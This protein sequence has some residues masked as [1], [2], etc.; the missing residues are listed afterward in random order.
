[1]I[2]EYRL[3]VGFTG[4][5]GDTTP[6]GMAHDVAVVR[7]R[8]SSELS[9][10][11]DR[12][13][14][15]EGGSLSG[16]PL[17]LGTEIGTATWDA[18][19]DTFTVTFPTSNLDYLPPLTNLEVT[20]MYV[21]EG[22]GSNSIVTM[23][24]LDNVATTTWTPSTN[25]GSGGGDPTA[26]AAYWS[27]DV[28]SE[29]EHQAAE[30]CD[31]FLQDT[32]GTGEACGL[33]SQDGDAS[34][35]VS[36]TPAGSADLNAPIQWPPASSSAAP[37]HG[38]LW[39]I[40]D[41]FGAAPVRAAPVLGQGSAQTLYF[42]QGTVPVGNLDTL[43]ANGNG[44]DR[45]APTASEPAAFGA[46]N[47]LTNTASPHTLSE[48]C[49]IY[50]GDI[51]LS[52]APMTVA[53][54]ASFAG[55][56]TS[57]GTVPWQV[58]VYVATGAANPNPAT[59]TAS[60]QAAYDLS[61]TPT[62]LTMTIPSVTGTGDHLY[63][64]VTPVNAV[65]G[66]ATGG[67]ILY[68]S[69]D[70]PSGVQVGTSTGSSSTS[71]SS[72]SSSST[73]TTGSPAVERVELYEASALLGHQDVTTSGASPTAS[74]S[75]S[76]LDLG[77]GDHTLTAKWFDAAVPSSGTPL[78]TADV[79]FTV[80]N[81]AD[82]CDADTTDPTISAAT[83][84]ATGT[85][86]ATVSW[87]T[88]EASDGVVH[89]GTTAG[90]GSDATASGT[91]SHSASLSGL[92]A[93]TTYH[94][95]VE[96]T[97]AC[98]NTAPSGDQTFTTDADETPPTTEAFVTID[99]P[100]D[101]AS[102]EDAAFTVDGTAGHKEA[103]VVGDS[104]GDGFVVIAVPDTGINPYHR[105]FWEDTYPRNTDSDP[106][107]DVDFRAYPGT[108]LDGFPAA[109]PSLD[110]T[111]D[112]GFHLGAD[113]AKFSTV[114]TGSLRWI[115]GTKIIGAYDAGDATTANGAADT[116]P[117][118]D[119]EGT[120]L[121]AGGHGTA[122]SSVAAGNLF[123]SCKECLLVAVESFG[124]D[125]WAYSQDWIDIVT[126]SGGPVANI[127]DGSVGIF[128]DTGR[129]FAPE[130]QQ[131]AVE[132]GVS[133]LYAG[134]NG[135]DGNFL[136]PGQTYL[137]TGVGPGW[138]VRVGAVNNEP[139][140]F[141]DGSYSIVQSNKPVDISSYGAGTI[142][143]AC[144]TDS[145]GDC[146]HS[147]TSS[148]TPITAGH[149]G[150]LILHA[151]RMLGDNG[152]T[153]AFR[154]TAIN[155]GVV[156]SGTPVAGNPYLEDGKFTRAE[157]WYI[158]KQAASPL[159]PSPVDFNHIVTVGVGATPVDYAYAGYGVVDDDA[160]ARAIAML[161]DGTAL[162]RDTADAD[163]FFALD[164][165]VRGALWGGWD[166]DAD[167]L[168]APALS[169]PISLEALGLE[170][171]D[172]AGD[173]D[174]LADALASLQAPARAPAMAASGALGPPC[175]GTGAASVSVYLD[176]VAPANLLGTDDLSGADGAC[177]DDW[178][179]DVDLT[180]AT[181]GTHALVAVYDDGADGEAT[182][183]V[184]ISLD[185]I[186]VLQDG[187]PVTVTLAA[188]T[189]R[190]YRVD[191]PAGTDL[192]SVAIDGPECDPDPTVGCT[193]DADLFV[194]AG[195]KPT[196]AEVCSAPAAPLND[197]DCGTTVCAPAEGDSDEACDMPEPV[198]GIWYVML[199]PYAGS[200]TLTLVADLDPADM[201]GDGVPDARDDD[202]NGDGVPDEVGSGL[203]DPSTVGDG[204]VAFIQLPTDPSNTAPVIV[205]GADLTIRVKV[206]TGPS[207]ALANSGAYR[208]VLQV[209]CGAL[210]PTVTAQAPGACAGGADTTTRTKAY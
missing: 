38:I 162:L 67:V 9:A 82:P 174:L 77:A 86:T 193:F 57:P 72:S 126:V 145:T 81:G 19:S 157:A 52:G 196:G 121:F 128:P 68:D 31:S 17:S 32:T 48:P 136:T 83:A 106:A 118:F 14:Q 80:S 190:Y 110:L 91:T 4:P 207:Y 135:N 159:A 7:A 33:Y 187:Q 116:L 167:T 25:G 163:T 148:A 87:S 58:K 171:L 34:D 183:Q 15:V 111:I 206:Y 161:D 70:Y 62:L 6:D 105:D 175:L 45:T 204:M 24:E 195:A 30:D 144:N 23:D 89:Y 55:A 155:A 182:A 63:V 158:L 108:Y 112:G 168:P 79:T 143:A 127:P 140:P 102:L 134:G 114:P 27:T 124:G 88:D 125:E 197:A 132:R 141:Q 76:G 152:R 99:S 90:Y 150:D 154:D 60:K 37:R 166:D 44:M 170:P 97:D 39:H 1:H 51:D 131:E 49:W 198:A 46:Q 85:T 177:S 184:G 129:F 47:E 189:D 22:T 209:D 92:T 201:D 21:I 69:T 65:T 188:A 142:P 8:G 185:T 41:L 11:Y 173:S 178:S 94:Y 10:T 100:L 103:A 147:G 2:L 137:S 186:G 203:P 192:L 120:G 71:S 56:G 176:S 123:G 93:A 16:G 117:L 164:Q 205:G 169:T 75:V 12:K 191:V 172:V 73:S 156:A 54:Y 200:G 146:G 181:A 53:W 5:T 43:Y 42:H 61:A 202:A 35:P 36:C 101:G 3:N 29:E 96:S 26:C 138:N 130:G 179:V 133:L 28:D 153:G 160:E 165:E 194:K 109:V 74:W 115:P 113:T 199:H 59:P 20:S 40:L 139:F 122:S 210:Q 98:G 208:L 119:D 50:V 107:N 180:G 149:L 66:L 95:Q 18:A 151:R 104:N 84:T 78:D 13:V 64:Q